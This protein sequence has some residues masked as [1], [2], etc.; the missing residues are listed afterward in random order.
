MK[1]TDA[2]ISR[3]E[4][5]YS[6]LEEGDD[7]FDK[8]KEVFDTFI[9]KINSSLLLYNNVFADATHLN[10]ASRGKTICRITSPV[11]EI[12]VIYL[13]TP[14]EVCLKRNSKRQGRELVPEH[15]IK[16]MYSRIKLPEK[17]EGID[18]IYIIEQNKP[19]NI[20]KL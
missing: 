3:D 13:K 4:V 15:V 8:E 6:L 14:L 2:Y 20:I 9:K 11:D 16:D 7:Y 10:A 5:R 19:I 18:N 17:E 1:P 12:N